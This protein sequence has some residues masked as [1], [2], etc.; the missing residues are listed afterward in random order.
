METT[1]EGESVVT[2]SGLEIITIEKG[3]G[4]QPEAGSI[5]VVHY[6]GTLEDGTKFDSSLDR[7]Q[8]FQFALGQGQV[9]RGWDEGI[10]R[11]H[12]G[13]KAKLVI[14]PELGYGERG[15]GNVIP[16]NAT[17]I[18]E[19]ELIDILEGSPANPTEV[20]EADYKETE[21]GLKYYDF[22]VGEGP[23]PEAGATVIVHYTG[24]L[25]D[26]TKFDSSI[27]RGS[28]FPF[29]V[30]AGQVI[31]GWDEGV[32]SMTVGTKRQLVIPPELG[33]GERGAG[34]G[35]IPSN[36]TLIF[37]VELLEIQ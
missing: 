23:T 13:G 33:Y 6:T 36:A 4:P 3:T 2:E 12:V 32:G 22:E 24:W 16:P 17:L 10:A 19:V 29:T 20:N 37:E 5:V 28:P 15:A 9:I 8:P 30:G 14:P 31:R 11:L 7:N 1:T 26:G 21:S 27:D 18:F 34:N 25:E 35:V